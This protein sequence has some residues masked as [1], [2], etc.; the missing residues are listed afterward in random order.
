M[1]RLKCIYYSQKNIQFTLEIHD[2]EAVSDTN[3]D[4]DM[5]LEGNPISNYENDEFNVFSEIASMSLSFTMYL[6]DANHTSFHSDFVLSPEGR[7]FVKVIDT[8]GSPSVKFIGKLTHDL[9]SVEDGPLPKL[10]L[11]AMDGMMELASVDFTP[12]FNFDDYASIFI[13]RLLLKSSV[14]AYFFPNDTDRILN[15]FNNYQNEVKGTSVDML[16]YTYVGSYFNEEI[17]GQKK[18]KKCLEVL[19]EMLRGMGARMYFDGNVYVLEQIRTR[20]NESPSYSKYLRDA[21]YDGEF[22]NNYTDIEFFTD[23]V[24]F[25]SQE[26]TILAY[27]TYTYVPPIRSAILSQDGTQF[28]NLLFGLFYAD[29][30]TSGLQQVSLI[31]DLGSGLKIYATVN[32]NPWVIKN[33]DY[34]IGWPKYGYVVIAVQIRVGTRYLRGTGT[35]LY[36]S[37]DTELHIDASNWSTDTSRRVQIIIPTNV[38]FNNQN[39]NAADANYKVTIVSPLIEAIGDVYF[40]VENTGVYTNSTISTVLDFFGSPGYQNKWI[41]SNNSLSI[42]TNLNESIDEGVTITTIVNDTDN[43]VIYN[44]GYDMGDFPGTTSKKRIRIDNTSDSDG[45]SATGLSEMPFQELALNDI[46]GFRRKAR[47]ILTTTMVLDTLTRPL[48]M[49]DRLI[50]K[51]DIFIPLTMQSEYSLDTYTIIWFEVAQDLVSL[52]PTETTLPDVANGL[53]NGTVVTTN[54]QG[55]EDVSSYY[56]ED[57]MAGSSVE[58]T[59]F[60]LF[61]DPSIYSMESINHSIKIHV[62]SDMYHIVDAAVSYLSNTQCRL[63]FSTKEIEFNRDLTGRLIRVDATNK[64]VLST[65]VS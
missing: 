35:I 29:Y 14:I 37:T 8:S 38:K 22:N 64:Y 58:P 42:V 3:Y 12:T 19:R 23:G 33:E 36:G 54:L 44:V 60:E 25:D 53:T 10:T 34:I 24:A 26:V 52:P 7:F 21:S 55:D 32:I 48:S 51:G 61:P 30:T 6:E 28:S 16:S 31:D 39:P 9:A 1:V 20:L 18:E 59:D 63:N 62:G 4:F 50:Y 17:D 15:V 47:K 41:V 49:L 11:S 65:P 43:T 5:P 27:P 46:V 13:Q 40:N 56:F 2:T 45:W 57:T